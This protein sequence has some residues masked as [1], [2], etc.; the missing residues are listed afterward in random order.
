[1]QEAIEAW[2]GEGGGMRQRLKKKSHPGLYFPEV[3]QLL[4]RK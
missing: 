2:E 4:Q 1:M 3:T